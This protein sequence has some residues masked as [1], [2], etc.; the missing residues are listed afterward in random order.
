MKAVIVAGGLGTRLSE[1][2]MVRPKPM[3]G[4]GGK[5]MLGP[6]MKIYSHY[7][8]NKGSVVGAEPLVR[9]EVPPYA[10]AAG[11]PARKIAYCR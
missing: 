8:S 6:I 9:A 11:V 2:T 7:G 3:V 10:I 4:L 5:P 1:E